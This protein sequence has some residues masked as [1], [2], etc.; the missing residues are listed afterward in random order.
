MRLVIDQ[1]NFNIGDLHHRFET[2]AGAFDDD[3]NLS[4]ESHKLYN[5]RIL[6]DLDKELDFLDKLGVSQTAEQLKTRE[7][8]KLL[9]DT[10][11]ASAQVSALTLKKFKEEIYERK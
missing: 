1:H 10:A 5:E 9:H 6:T 2:I 3:R 8:Q 11:S 7:L 4:K